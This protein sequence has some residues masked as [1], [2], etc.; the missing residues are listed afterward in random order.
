MTPMPREHAPDSSLALLADPYR[1]IS[2]RCREHGSDVF[3]ARLMLQPTI[4]MSGARAAELFYDPERF[5]RCRAAPEP[6]RATLFGKGAVQSL[7]GA[8]HRRR[9]ALFLELLTPEKV[10]DLADR[11]AEGWRRCVR[12]W[13]ADGR[14]VVLYDAMRS[15]LTRAVC[16]WAGV[17]LPEPEVARRTAQLTALYD[18]AASLQ[19]LHA[20][21]QRMRAEAWLAQLIEAVRAH[22]FE[23]RPGSAL[24]AVAWHRDEHER[25]LAPRIA[26]VELLN[27]LRPT[28]AVSVFIVQA[29]HA[30]HR[31][32]GS[33]AALQAGDPEA[34]ERF[35]QEVRRHY[36]FF[37][38]VVARVRRDFDWEGFR[39]PRGR[40]TMLDLYG[41][42]HDPRVWDDPDAFRPERFTDAEPGG[43]RFVPQG[44]GEVRTN[45]RCPGEP[46][47]VALMKVS[48]D[49]LARRM[50][51]A[52]PPQDLR[53][54]FA[55]L[56]ALP[57]SGFVIS[58]VRAAG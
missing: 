22:R 49:F 40:R 51:Y 3:E 11:V 30:L 46:V 34:V 7:D 57:R 54:D 18:E 47:A 16:A 33:R 43:F 4:C 45:H 19:H 21:L 35:V 9:K 12:G 29:A 44:G 5:E 25:L 27:L 15:L 38:A 31:Y 55:R 13:A 17:P 41:T 10:E 23:A 36:P 48:V 32:P 42:D 58:D 8:A 56:P 2:R 6:L 26:A 39:F 37:P 1:Y 53:L 52:L 20:R 28:V 24:D 14:R 50:R